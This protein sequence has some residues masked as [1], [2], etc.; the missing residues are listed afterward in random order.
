MI[1]SIYAGSTS[2]ARSHTHVRLCA[3]SLSPIA[4]LAFHPPIIDAHALNLATHREERAL[5]CEDAVIALTKP[6]ESTTHTGVFAIW[7][8]RRRPFRLSFSTTTTR[9][10]AQVFL[11]VLIEA[12]RRLSRRRGEQRRCGS[13]VSTAPA[14]DMNVSDMNAY[15]LYSVFIDLVS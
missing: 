9:R 3:L 6:S 2:M 8:Y 4:V 10:G 5:Y 1:S 13:P 12:L 7:I 14:A 15:I 11:A